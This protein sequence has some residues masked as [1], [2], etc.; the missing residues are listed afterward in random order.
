VT[1]TG[2]VEPARRADA[3][4]HEEDTEMTRRPRGELEA[5][6]LGV[7]WDATDWMSPQE[8]SDALDR[9]LAYT[10]VTTVLTR[11]VAK[12]TVERRPAGRGFTYRPVAS[13]E[14]QAA[15]RLGEVLA[16]AGDRTVT[17][18]RFVESLDHEER[19][20]LRRAIRKAP[21]SS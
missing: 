18:S 20:R 14:E 16:A 8:V 4:A 17:L 7:L 6:V 13:R 12:G 10:T 5:S 21:P 19:E 2:R 9:S 3:T 1:A 11:L 15:A